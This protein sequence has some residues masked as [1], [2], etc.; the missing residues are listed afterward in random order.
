MKC[1]LLAVVFCAADPIPSVQA[2]DHVGQPAMV[3][4]RIANAGYP[5]SPGQAAN[6]TD[7]SRQFRVAFE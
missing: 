7:R 3:C 2:R 6:R 1:V 4:G 5:D